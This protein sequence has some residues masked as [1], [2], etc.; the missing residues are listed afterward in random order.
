MDL[1]RDRNRIHCVTVGGPIAWRLTRKRRAAPVA[2][3]GHLATGPRKTCPRDRPGE[4]PASAQVEALYQLGLS[5]T[6]VRA[7]QRLCT[8]SARQFEF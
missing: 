1:L 8:D 5:R 4:P 2:Q 7:T 3:G 6:F